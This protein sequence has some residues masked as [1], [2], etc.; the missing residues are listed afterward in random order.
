MIYLDRNA[1]GADTNLP[2]KG[3]AVAP[4]RRTEVFIHHTT[5]IS[6]EPSRNTWPDLAGVRSQM[7][8]LQVARAADL[9]AD[10]PYSFV[11]FILGSGE[12]A[13][14]EGRGFD[15]S[16]AHTP[17]HNSSAFGIA[18]QGNF[19][20]EDPPA[21]FDQRLA[22]LGDWLRQLQRDGFGRLGSR[23]PD[24][25][26]VW[27]HLDVKA[28]LCPGRYLFEKLDR[29]RFMGWEDDEMA[30]DKATWQSVQRALQTLEPPLYGGK[31]IDGLPG[32]NT[33]IAVQA[34]ER[35]MA[36]DSRGVLGDSADPQ[37]GIWPATRELLY[38][39]AYGGRV[40]G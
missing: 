13:I 16:G 18:I 1:W 2:R 39:V 9:G 5:I 21:G 19:E 10:V 27:A 24:G 17:G 8:I 23:R 32:R 20:S 25:R 34:F 7:K 28:T 30:M 33:D 14:C 36:L 4:D 31:A 11:V 3:S 26:D 6:R 40:G 22:E 37:A 35:R 12:L 38:A 15:R 29:I